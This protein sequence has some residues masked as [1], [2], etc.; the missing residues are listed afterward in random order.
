MQL[1]TFNDKQCHKA[2]NCTSFNKWALCVHVI[3]YSNSEKLDWYGAEYR[4][5]KNFVKKMK[6]GAKSKKT[7]RFS[8]ASFALKK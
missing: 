4:Q 7:G 1:I 2:C 6:K 8:K 3:A 5:P